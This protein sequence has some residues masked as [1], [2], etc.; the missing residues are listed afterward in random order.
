MRWFV[1][2]LLLANIGLYFWVQYQARLSTGFRE[3]P[4]PDIG[5]LRLMREEMQAANGQVAATDGPDASPPAAVEDEEPAPTPKP[6][7]A[8]IPGPV[9]GIDM[10]AAGSSLKP[11]QPSADTLPAG[12]PDEIPAASP[13]SAPE[14]LVADVMDDAVDTDEVAAPA[15][16]QTPVVP[17]PE[18]RLRPEPEPGPE[19][20]LVEIPSSD[21]DIAV[22]DIAPPSERAVVC[23]KIGPFTAEQAQQILARLPPGSEVEDDVTG[24]HAVENGFFVLIPKL[25]SRAIGRQTL[26]ALKEAGVTD[27]WLFPSGPNEN[28]ISLGFFSRIDSARKH[29][30]SVAAKGFET[31]IS[32]RVSSETR[33]W[34]TL[35]WTGEALSREDFDAPENVDRVVVPCSDD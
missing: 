30:E 10:E 18:S 17:E 8:G 12:R 28:A 22:V 24:A 20:A 9:P 27:T 35:R 34:L 7:V 25:P 4:A 11:D 15:A 32:P 13:G 23:E 1:V 33:R 26:A 21:T 3:L 2:F 19:P 5:H 6:V 14:P 31:A 16:V 29:A